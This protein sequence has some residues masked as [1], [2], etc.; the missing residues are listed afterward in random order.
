M[1]KQFLETTRRAKFRSLMREYGS[2]HDAGQGET[3]EALDLLAEALS[4][5]P[6]EMAAKRD[7]II[8][9]VYGAWPEADHCDAN[10]EPVY[11]IA[12]LEKWLGHKIDPKDIER[13]MRR[14]LNTITIHKIQ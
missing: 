4:I 1:D 7:E 8:E 9:E 6:P 14:F 3:E 10:G 5:A 2:L 12:Q 11:T 13:V